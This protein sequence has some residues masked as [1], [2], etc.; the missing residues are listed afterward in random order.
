[1]KRCFRGGDTC[2]NRWYIDETLSDVSSYDRSSSYPDVLVNCQFPVT[3]FVECQQEIDVPYLEK[4]IFQRN[5]A[6]IFEIRLTDVRLKNKYWGDPYLTKDKS[7]NI[8]SDAEIMNGRIL[9]CSSLETVITDVDYRIIRET[10]DYNIKILAWFKASKGMLPQCFR[11]YIIKLYRQ[12][13]E[14]KGLIG[15]TPE[16]TEYN[17]RMYG[18]AKALLNAVYG[19]TATSPIKEMI[20]YLK[21]DRDFHYE[22]KSEEEL[23]EDCKKRYWLPYEWGIYCTAWARFRLYEGISLVSKNQS[24]LDSRFSDFIY[25]DTDSVKYLGS[26]DWSAYNKLRME[27]SKRNGAYA[28]DPKGVTHYCGV[29]EEEHKMNKFRTCGSKKYAF[30]IDGK[31]SVTIAGVDKKLGGKELA[32]HGGIDALQDGFIFREAGGLCAKYNDF[33]SPDKITI[34]GHELQIISNCYLCESEYTLGTI[35][36]YKRILFMAKADLDRIERIMYN[37]YTSGQLEE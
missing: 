24:Y 21:E 15:S 37:E 31:L 6:I 35:E 16:E 33:P 12:K 1:M 14:L 29:Y 2:A 3:P 13:T 32:K 23:F 7:R 8:S 20:E 11:D 4:L 17:E 36:L 34:D 18:K 27:D 9:S 25:C 19:M 10:Y 22:E 30:V 28:T 5:R 26:A